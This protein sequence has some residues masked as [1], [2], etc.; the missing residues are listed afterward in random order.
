VV[1]A[2]L[3]ASGTGLVFS[4]FFGG[5]GY[6]D[7]LSVA[8]DPT[9]KPVI[10]GGTYSPDFPLEGAFQGTIGGSEDAF[11]TKFS[12]DG[13]SLVY[14]TFVGGAGYDLARSVAVDGTNRVVLTG[15]TQ[16]ADFPVSHAA[17]G[18]LTGGTDA[19]VTKMSING[20]SLIFS[21]YLGGNSSDYGYGVAADEDGNAYAGGVTYSSDMPQNNQFGIYTSGGYVTK[22]RSNGV[23]AY[24][25]ILSASYVYG[26]AV[27]SLK[28]PVVTGYSYYGLPPSDGAYQMA[29][30]G[31][32]DAFLCRL[33]ANGTS[34]LYSTYLGGSIN[35]FGYGVAV[36]AD[37]DAYITGYS[38]SHDYPVTSGAF[39]TLFVGGTNPQSFVSKIDPTPEPIVIQPIP[40][41]VGGND[42]TIT[43]TLQSP[44]GAGGETIAL[45]G[46]GGVVTLPA[47]AF[48]AA[49]E[50]TT[51]FTA[52]TKGVNV[53]R[54]AFVNAKLGTSK[55]T[56]RFVLAAARPAHVSFTPA[57]VVGGSGTAV[58]GKVT[59]DGKAGPAGVYVFLSARFLPSSMQ[60]ATIPSIVFVPS[61]K[62][63]VK[64]DVTHEH[65]AQNVTMSVTAS[66]N[67]GS[68]TGTLKIK[69]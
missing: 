12:A 34:L 29:P 4:T 19:F 8:L 22:F 54:A 11:V 6:E 2:K 20:A 64:F 45:S 44:A 15:E 30:A 24:T 33:A 65:T 58:T 37:N 68:A 57:N 28:R 14:S 32:S 67:G 55:S 43:I 36:D 18:T 1:L 38:L 56:R 9:G 10:A 39:D 53:E 17:Q 26:I 42:V 35:D 52:A 41:V 23:I 50:T 13:Q 27:D 31:G 47:T 21:T 25:D 48:V 46:G 16:S 69:H 59:L 66:A 62:T 49:G 60:H 40:S 51:S 7:G 63:L 5:N 3:N 61:G